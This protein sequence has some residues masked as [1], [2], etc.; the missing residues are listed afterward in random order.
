MYENNTMCDCMQAR[1]RGVGGVVVVAIVA[2]VHV[3]RVL[4]ETHK[5]RN[6]LRYTPAFDDI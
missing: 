6:N 1:E 3:K 5:K 2:G 4:Y